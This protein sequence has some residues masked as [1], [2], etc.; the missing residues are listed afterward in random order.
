MDNY[1]RIVAIEQRLQELMH[2]MNQTLLMVRYLKVQL[3]PPG[4]F[5]HIEEDCQ[6]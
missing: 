4:I 1:Q 3:E 5:K 2:K 6:D